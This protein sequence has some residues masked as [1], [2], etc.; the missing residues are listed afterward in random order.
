MVG[1]TGLHRRPGPSPT[2]ISV[3][4]GSP[5]PKTRFVRVGHSCSD[6][7]PQGRVECHQATQ[8]APAP[9][10]VIVVVGRGKST[11]AGSTASRLRS[12]LDFQRSPVV[13]L[14]CHLLSGKRFDR[15]G[16][17]RDSGPSSTSRAVTPSSRQN[18]TCSSTC[19]TSSFQLLFFSHIRNGDSS[20]GGVAHSSVSSPTTSS[21][22]RSAI[23]RFS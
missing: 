20:I 3:A 1:P 22:I 2:N 12:G 13:G 11:G 10:L 8:A 18:R 15:S 4:C 7:N 19:A 17:P 6:D 9:D 21:R 14:L 5:S 16:W 23:S